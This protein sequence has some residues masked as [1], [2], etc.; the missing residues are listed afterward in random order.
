M[1]QRELEQAERWLSSYESSLMVHDGV[2]PDRPW[3]RST[4]THT[5]SSST[6]VASHQVFLDRVPSCVLQES[7]SDVL[8][9]LK[10]QEDLEAMIQ[11][12]TDRFNTLQ[13]RRTK[14]GPKP[15]RESA[16]L[17]SCRH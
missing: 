5:F 14:V 16:P 13:K 7:V 8:E 3:G 9:L 11:A 10:R 17:E 4:W 6:G 2:S 12:Q 1:L 15:G